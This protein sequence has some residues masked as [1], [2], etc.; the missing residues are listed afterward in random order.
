MAELPWKIDTSITV[1]Q[2]QK[3]V[4]VEDKPVVVEVEKGHIKRFVEA[5]G[6]SNPL[7]QDPVYAKDSVYEKP[8]APPS[9]I[10]GANMMGSVMPNMPRPREKVLDGGAEWEFF[11]PIEAGD[12]ISATTCLARLFERELKGLGKA[13]FFVLV[14]THTN[15]RKE[16]VARSNAT[17][18]CY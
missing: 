9:I 5:V 14:T 10:F 17:I 18:I 8:V 15:Q 4:G 3:M 16:V 2:L 1:E 13:I 12:T 11:K 7:W 6:D